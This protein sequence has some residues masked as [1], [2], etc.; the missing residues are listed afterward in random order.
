M[1]GRD[2]QTQDVPGRAGLVGRQTAG[3]LQD[4]GREHR[5]VGDDRADGGQTAGVLGRIGPLEDVTGTV[6]TGEAHLDPH[7]GD[8]G[9]RLEEGADVDLQPLAELD[10]LV[11]GPVG[12]ELD[13]QGGGEPERAER[14]RVEREVPGLINESDAVLYN[15]T[16]RP[17]YPKP[18]R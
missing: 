13:E 7:P 3:Q 12:D 10:Q 11:V 18:S 8:G 14:E 2:R 6:A 1:A 17:E 5:L 16:G 4:R 15:W 9:V